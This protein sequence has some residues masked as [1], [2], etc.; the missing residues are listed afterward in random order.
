M[1]KIGSII[2][3]VWCALN[4][5]PALGIVGYVAFGNIHPL[6]PARFSEA[7]INAISP[8]VLDT[9]NGMAVFANGHVVALCLI[10]LI[11]IWKGL[12]KKVVWVF[13][14]LL[15]SMTAASLAGFAAGYVDRTHYYDPS[16]ISALLL[17][18]GFTCAA[19]GLFRFTKS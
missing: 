15:I 7:E 18:A 5:L 4:M 14:A 2:L 12:N 19:M 17:A 10:A 6:L 16:I 11:A 1:L 8:N 3:S 9:I 13:W